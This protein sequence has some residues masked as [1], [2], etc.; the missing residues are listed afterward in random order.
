MIS[1]KRIWI[2]FSIAVAGGLGGAASSV[3]RN[4]NLALPPHVCGGL[5]GLVAFTFLYTIGEVLS[6]AVKSSGPDVKKP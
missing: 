3:A 2:L 1:L 4:E 6:W 5:V